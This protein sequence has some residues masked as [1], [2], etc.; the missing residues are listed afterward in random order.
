[1]YRIQVGYAHVSSVLVKALCTVAAVTF[2]R[3]IYHVL[4]LDCSRSASCRF[5]AS[6]IWQPD[7]TTQKLC[8]KCGKA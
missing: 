1:M 3:E 4:M 2:D 8:L 7:E 6:P 5:G